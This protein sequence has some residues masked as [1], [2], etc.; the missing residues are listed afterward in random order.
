M[1]EV[2][3]LLSE[4]LTHTKILSLGKHVEH[5]PYDDSLSI[6]FNVQL[7]NILIFQVYYYFTLFLIFYLY[8]NNENYSQYLPL[9]FTL[10]WSVFDFLRF[11]HCLSFFLVLPII[12]FTFAHTL[13]LL[14][15]L[16]TL[17]KGDSMRIAGSP[18]WECV[19]DKE[20]E[21]CTL[22]RLRERVHVK[23]WERGLVNKIYVRR[24]ERSCKKY[25]S[26]SAEYLIQETMRKSWLKFYWW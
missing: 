8:I 24:L 21:R 26:S 23:K 20:K 6:Y 5:I 3:E 7:F 4:C 2:D 25:T 15:S 17:S 10:V 16:I 1:W 19:F 13:F 18:K 12:S 14:L 11:A 22:A 9:L